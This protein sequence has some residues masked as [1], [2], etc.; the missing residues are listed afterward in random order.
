MVEKIKELEKLMTAELQ[1]IARY[2]N[3]HTPEDWA[4]CVL[5]CETGIEPATVLYVSNA[6]RV[7]MVDIIEKWIVDMKAENY[8]LPDQSELKSPRKKS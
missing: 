2:V 7:Q 3:E 6:D 5:L 1:G 8:R 4:F